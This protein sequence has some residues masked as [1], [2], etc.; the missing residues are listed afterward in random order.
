MRPC[1][2][3]GVDEETITT[4]AALRELVGE[5]GQ[6]TKD[7]V[8]DRLLDAHRQWLAHTPFVVL[9]TSD[10]QG[11]C[12]A[13]PKGDPAGNLVTVL[14]ER[15]VALAERPGNKRVD[16]YL[17]VLDNPHVGLVCLIPGRGDTLRINGRAT[18]VRDA[19]WFDQL[20]VQDRRPMLALTIDVDEV[21]FH[22]AKSLVRSRL[23]HPESWNPQAVASPAELARMSERPDAA[24][25]ALEEYQLSQYWT[26]LY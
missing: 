14:D 3:G 8:G 16:G 2:A 1:E 4:P 12:D 24:V 17:N 11:R 15:R 18:L 20:V 6:L 5:P 7:K 13:S 10:A 9:A 25:T 23:W 22:C 21:F 26:G 19:P